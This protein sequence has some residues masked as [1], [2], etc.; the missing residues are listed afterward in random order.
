MTE[1]DYSPDAYERYISN[2][3]RV[4]NWVDRTEEHRPE[5][6]REGGS[7]PSKFSFFKRFARRR[8]SQDDR[9]R[10]RSTS[11]A[12]STSSASIAPYSTLPHAPGPTPFAPRA[13]ERPR[14]T[15]PYLMQPEQR[16]SH[17]RHHSSSHHHR[18]VY[19]ASPP[20]SPPVQGYLYPY[21]TAT[22][23]GQPYAYPSQSGIS[24]AGS[25]PYYQPATTSYFPQNTGYQMPTQYPTA[26]PYSTRPPLHHTPHTA[27]ATTYQY[28]PQTHVPAQPLASPPAQYPQTAAYPPPAV[29]PLTP[30]GPQQPPVPHKP[31]F[32]QRIFS[33]SGSGSKR[34]KER[35]H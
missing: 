30:Y 35:R 24:T 31:V 5:F 26:A 23:P 7:G 6:E 8:D 1:Y 20:I 11:P 10:H 22:T 27:P 34:G 18:P 3:Q 19:L 25:P 14:T 17:S 13:I 28:Y 29:Y 33:G 32:Y 16:P 9:R 21:G 15:P 12:S 2:Q 4:A